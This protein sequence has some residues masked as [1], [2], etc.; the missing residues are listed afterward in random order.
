MKVRVQSIHFDA[1]QKLLQFVNEKVDKLTQF[2]DDIIDSEVG[3]TRCGSGV[4]KQDRVR[5]TVG[6]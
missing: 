4:C 6:E 5:R 1:D 2:F 3:S